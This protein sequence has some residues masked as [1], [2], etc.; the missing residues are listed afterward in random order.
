[1]STTH[2]A[3]LHEGKTFSKRQSR[4]QTVEVGFISH[5]EYISLQ[6]SLSIEGFTVVALSIC[7]WSPQGTW[8][9]WGIY[10]SVSAVGVRRRRQMGCHG[11][12]SACQS[13]RWLYS[14]HCLL[15]LNSLLAELW[16][17]LSVSRC[18]HTPQ[19]P[20]RKSSSTETRT[21]RLSVKQLWL[22]SHP[23]M[24]AN[25]WMVSILRRTD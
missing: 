3:T 7:L 11:H 15:A 17:I 12:S 14:P 4:G 1:M 21:Q 2:I 8:I 18:G 5:R 6:R 9:R 22:D 24:K 16:L 23:S 19:W 13:G 10:W 25:N 20:V